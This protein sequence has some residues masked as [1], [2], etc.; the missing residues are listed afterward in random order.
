MYKTLVSIFVNPS[1]FNKKTDYEKY[2]RNINNDLKILKKLK[3]DYV[4]IPSIKDIY[5]TKKQ[6][7]IKLKKKIKYYAQNIDLVILKVF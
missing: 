3:V 4:L 5:K 1:Q 2:P 6:M 7:K